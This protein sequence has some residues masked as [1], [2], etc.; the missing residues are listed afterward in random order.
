MRTS[1]RD[2]IANGVPGTTR[3]RISSQIESN[4]YGIAGD[5]PAFP[6]QQIHDVAKSSKSR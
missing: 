6:R 5:I 3:A 2:L 1:L 4:V